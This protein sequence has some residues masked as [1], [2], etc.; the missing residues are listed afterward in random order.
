MVEAAQVTLGPG[1]C[2]WDGSIQ[3]ASW[4]SPTRGRA[5]GV[6]LQRRSFVPGTLLITSKHFSMSLI[7]GHQS[8]SSTEPRAKDSSNCQGKDNSWSGI[9]LMGKFV[10]T[11]ARK[12]SKINYFIG[13]R[14]AGKVPKMKRERVSYW[15]HQSKSHKASLLQDPARPGPQ[16]PAV[17][18]INPLLPTVHCTGGFRCFHTGCSSAWD[19]LPGCPVIHSLLFGFC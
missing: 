9:S 10:S 5:K 19:V 14:G 6:H 11:R 2:W 8:S 12:T 4:T 7:S 18:L 1:P 16:L 15:Y 17:L 13:C 3:V